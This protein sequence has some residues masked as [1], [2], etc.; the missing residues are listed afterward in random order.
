[1]VKCLNYDG[2]PKCHDCEVGDG[3]KNQHGTIPGCF[4]NSK[5]V[6]YLKVA[7]VGSE[8]KK[9]NEYQKVGAKSFIRTILSNDNVKVMISGDCPNGG[10]DKWAESIAGDPSCGVTALIYSPEINRWKD[11]GGEMG[12]RT[13]NLK[14]A[15]N[16]DI[17]YDLEPKGKRSG[18]TWTA[19]QAEKMGK[20]VYYV[21]FDKD[22]HGVATPKL[23]KSI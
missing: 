20:D 6:D 10:V 22:G 9:W 18:G 1:M 23:G 7:I 19:E 21:F 8:E 15:R 3:P 12:F 11:K 2:S 13:R 5:I 4:N 16:C 14:I 17:L